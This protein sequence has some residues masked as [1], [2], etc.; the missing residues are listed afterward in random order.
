MITTTP[1][2]TRARASARAVTLERFLERPDTKPASEYYGPGEV[3]RK[4][5]PDHPHSRLQL[6]VAMLLWQYLQ[7]HPLGSVGPEWRC[8]FGPPGQERAWVPDVV[9]V[10]YERMPKGDAREHPYVMTAPDIAIEVLSRSQPALRFA[11]KLRFYL[12]HGVRLVWVLDPWQETITVFAPDAEER[13]L[14]PGDTLDGGDV[15]PGFSVPVAQIMAQLTD[16]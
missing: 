7:A 16:G 2:R 13:V 1:R 10:S 5:M 3:Y 4:P 12:A 14:R 6:F 8:I 9:Y 15:L 11:R